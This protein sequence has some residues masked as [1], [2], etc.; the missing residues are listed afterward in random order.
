MRGGAGVD[1][2]EGSAGVDWF[3]GGAGN[4]SCDAAAS[5]TV[6]KCEF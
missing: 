5:E 6:K 4:D 3:H 2:L 1:V